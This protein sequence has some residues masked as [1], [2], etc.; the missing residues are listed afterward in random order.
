MFDEI[1]LSDLITEFG[2]RYQDEGQT[3]ADIHKEIFE[4][5]GL[6]DEFMMI[7]NDNDEYKG[8]YATAED[9]L[10]AFSIP[11]A[12][13]GKTTYEPTRQRM[14]EFKIDTSITPDKFRKSYLGFLSQHAKD[15]DRSSWGVIEYILRD[16]LIPK[17][18]NQFKLE[19]AYYGWQYEG[20]AA[21]PTVNGTTFV[22]QLKAED[23]PN[24]A[25]AGM[26]GIRTQIARWAAASRTITIT[27]G[28]W[29]TDPETFCTQIE[30]FVW[31]S[32][33]QHLRGSI[34]DM[35]MSQTLHRRYR[36]GRRIKYNMNWGQ[37]DDL[38]LVE[39]TMIKVKGYTDMNGSENVWMT[40]KRNRVKPT[41][42]TGGKLFDIQKDKR[43]V[44]ILGD[45]SYVL[46]FDVPEFIVHSEHDTTID[47]SII[48]ARY[49][50]A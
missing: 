15:P 50:E 34:E 28:A 42:G 16:L 27:M 46:T 13:K 18:N 43:Y 9:V 23:T 31:D 17:A 22:R 32:S 2:N 36:Q 33:I 14:G 1:E 49:T 44:D 24:P 38:D 30:T 40:P 11:F 19:V 26:D 21:S 4:V 6:E 5:G 47:A 35:F 20:F 45:W 3:M 12:R 48:T 10:Q 39:D 37:V 7:P 41:R 25:N 29:S 8:V